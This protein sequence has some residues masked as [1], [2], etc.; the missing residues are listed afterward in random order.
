MEARVA[1]LV[2]YVSLILGLSVL[3]LATVLPKRTGA[4]AQSANW[5]QPNQP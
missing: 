5:N 2:R 3:A 1:A 4:K